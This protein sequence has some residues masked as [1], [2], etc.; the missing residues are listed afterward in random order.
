MAK[1]TDPH[2]GAGRAIVVTAIDGI[3]VPAGRGKTELTGQGRG[4]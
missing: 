3:S 1:P 4:V 2:V